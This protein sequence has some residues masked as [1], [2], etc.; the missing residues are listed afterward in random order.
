MV[1]PSI[2]KMRRKEL[3]TPIPA[4]RGAKWLAS[5]KIWMNE[6][7]S[8]TPE[9]K[10]RILQTF[11]LDQ[12]RLKKRRTEPERV[13]EKARSD[14]SKMLIRLALNL[15]FVKFSIRAGF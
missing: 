14:Q 1:K 11:S 6:T 13:E 7:P 8:K 5:G 4:S 9:P 10:A 2:E 15:E 12:S 3:K